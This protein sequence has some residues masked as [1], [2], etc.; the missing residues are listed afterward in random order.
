MAGPAPN[1]KITDAIKGHQGHH[2]QDKQ[3]THDHRVSAGSPA[4]PPTL[5]P[6]LPHQSED[7]PSLGCGQVVSSILVCV[8]TTANVRVV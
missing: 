1:P 4:L 7:S 3:E 8:P 5:P 6:A 2:P